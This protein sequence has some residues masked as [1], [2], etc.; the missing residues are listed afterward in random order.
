M[1]ISPF[2]LAPVLLATLACS[3][4][5]DPRKAEAAIAPGYPVAVPIIVPETATAQKGSA[6]VARLAKLKENLEKTGWFKI[7][8]TASSAGET[9][10]FQLLPTA[11]KAVT[12][13]SGGFSVPAAHAGFVR[14]V[15]VNQTKEGARVTYE[16][17]LEKPTAQFPLFQDVYPDATLGTTKVRYAEFQRRNGSWQL[18]STNEVFK[19]VQ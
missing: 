12:P 17:R 1:R 13:A 18:M 19:K 2:V 15:S 8:S 6:N 3:S 11:P 16:I 4:K 9:C 14:V 10:T 5:L 7:T